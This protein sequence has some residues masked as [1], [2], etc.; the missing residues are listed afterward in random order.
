MPSQP[1]HKMTCLASTIPKPYDCHAKR[2]TA[3]CS[4]PFNNT[5]VLKAIHAT[6]KVHTKGTG[7]QD[8]PI[9]FLSNTPTPPAQLPSYVIPKREPCSPSLWE[10]LPAEMVDTKTSYAIWQWH[11]FWLASGSCKAKA[12]P[13]ILDRWFDL[14]ACTFS[15]CCH[16]E[17]VAIPINKTGETTE[18]RR[19]NMVV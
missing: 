17:W 14:I 18:V 10:M 9:E 4:I 7:D 11:I 8:N 5:H 2:P 13:P 15:L 6:K 12:L 19:L 16:S 3:H 1:T